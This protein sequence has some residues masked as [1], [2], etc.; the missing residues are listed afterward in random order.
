MA[1]ADPVLAHVVIAMD[2]TAGA[3]KSTTSR[4]VARTLGLRYLDTGAM[5]RAITVAVLRSGVDLG[6]TAAVVANA[7]R[8]VIASRTSPSAPGI[9]LDGV[10][11][12][13][14]IRSQPVTAAVS[15]VSAIPEVREL[16][17]ALQRQEIGPGG[18]VVEGRDI[19]TVVVPD[20]D[21][22]IY[23]TADPSARARRRAAQLSAGAER[24][25]AGVEADLARRDDADSTRV[26]SPLS[27][28]PD[29]VLVDST[30]LSRE[31]VVARIVGLV[32]E[33]VVVRRG[34]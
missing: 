16:M 1:P 6:D 28:A 8:A 34:G 9:T 32:R 10:D 21:L 23:L 2:G 24:D 11:V 30:A 15:Q 29:A 12:R 20:A 31:E 33:R 22:K 5:Y 17:V 4:D 27:A 26:V 14:E 13:R 25:L 18:I 7:R 19:G 3:G